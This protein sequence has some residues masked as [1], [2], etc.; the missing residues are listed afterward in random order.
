M[1]R[2]LFRGEGWLGG[3]PTSDFHREAMHDVSHGNPPPAKE[4]PKSDRLAAKAVT[5]VTQGPSYRLIG[6]K[7]ELRR[8]LLRAS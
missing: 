8:H 4:R 3:L 6:R 5:L 1:M 2:H 7:V